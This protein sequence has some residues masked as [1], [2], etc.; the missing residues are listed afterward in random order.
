MSRDH[1]LPRMVIVSRRTRLE[2]L[3]ERHGTRSQARFYLETR[4]QKIEDLEHEHERFHAALTRVEQAIPPDQRRTRCERA[5]LDR[6]LFA[7]DDIVVIVGQDG[8]VPNTAKYLA[9]Q[10]T[11]GV[12]PDPARYDGILCPHPPEIAG[13]FLAWLGSRDASFRVEP[14]TMAVARREDGQRLL[15]L[16]EI[17][18]G[19]QSHQSARYRIVVKGREEHHSSSGLICSTGTGATGWARSIVRQRELRV[20]LPRPHQPKLAWF[21]R[22][23]FPSVATGAELDFGL[24]GRQTK[25]QLFS[26]MSEGG[27]IFADGIESDWLEFVSGHALEIGV[28]GETLRLV[29]PPAKP[30]DV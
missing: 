12:N 26:E 3:L 30:A 8:L 2:L 17:F 23:P 16:N 6:F 5:H 27:V 10:L 15:A 22:E 25:L 20:R 4:R 7:P 1:R 18:V 13:D 11:I 9:G 21:V 19:H 29:M 28:A 24:L 14:R